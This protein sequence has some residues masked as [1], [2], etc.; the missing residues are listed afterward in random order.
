MSLIK[1]GLKDLKLDLNK[2]K[3]GMTLDLYGEK[4]LVYEFEY[5]KKDKKHKRKLLELYTKWR[6]YHPYVCAI[7]NSRIAPS[8]SPSLYI[9]KDNSV[10]CICG[11]HLGSESMS[12]LINKWKEQEEIV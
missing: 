6:L 3:Q 4:A 10:R 9:A 8:E 5:Y 11:S 2:I 1:V 12:A 7:C